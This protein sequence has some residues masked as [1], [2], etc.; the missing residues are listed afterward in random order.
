MQLRRF[1]SREGGLLKRRREPGIFKAP[2]YTSRRVHRL[3][4]VEQSVLAG[5]GKGLAA[6]LV[7]L[8]AGPAV[9]ALYGAGLPFDIVTTLPLLLGVVVAGVL[10][11]LLVAALVARS[12]THVRPLSVLR[13]A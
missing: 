12:A 3:V 1:G 13:Y 9:H 8:V 11:C 5:L 10:L 2:G 6:L 7:A 4:L